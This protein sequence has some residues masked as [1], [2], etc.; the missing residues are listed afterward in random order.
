[1]LKNPLE[2][3]KKSMLYFF[4]LICT[5]F[6]RKGV[7]KHTILI[8]VFAMSQWDSQVHPQHHPNTVV[9]STN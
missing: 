7:P 9:G 6:F 3:N 2:N 1:M 5:F 4:C 8:I